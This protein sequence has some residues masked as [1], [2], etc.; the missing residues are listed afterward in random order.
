MESELSRRAEDYLKRFSKSR[1]RKVMPRI[2]RPYQIIGGV[3]P[4]CVVGND[5]KLYNKGYIFTRYGRHIP[6][7]QGEEIGRVIKDRH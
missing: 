2:K 7:S 1:K 6:N 4:A 5:G 3:K